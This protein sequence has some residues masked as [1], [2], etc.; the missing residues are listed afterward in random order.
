M[1]VNLKRFAI[2]AITAI[3]LCAGSASAP[4]KASPV[5]DYRAVD[6]A[7]PISLRPYTQV[8]EDRD[9]RLA[10]ADIL[11][12]EKSDPHRFRPLKEMRRLGAYSGSAWWL[13]TEIV[14]AA[15]APHALILVGG[16]PNLEQVDFYLQQDGQW[17]HFPAGTMIP[18]LQKDGATGYPA[19]QFTAAPGEAVAVWIRIESAS[20][21]RLEPALY[22]PGSFVAARASDNILGGV[23]TS[24]I[25]AL[26]ICAFILFAASH[27]RAFLW[28]GGICVTIALSEA[29]SRAYIQPVFWSMAS[30]WTYRLETVIHAIGA[31]LT[32]MFVYAMGQRAGL[33]AGHRKVYGVIAALLAICI[34]PT[35]FLPVAVLSMA[36][37]ALTVVMGICLMTSALG[38]ARQSRNGAILL[39]AAAVLLLAHA[40]GM[41]LHLPG[42]SPWLIPSALPQAGTPPVALFSMLAC[43]VALTLW[44][45]HRRKS[46]RVAPG[47]KQLAAKETG[48]LERD[49]APPHAQVPPATPAAVAPRDEAGHLATPQQ[50]LVLGYVGHDLRAPLAT[51]SG[52]ARLLRQTARPEQESYLDMIER[53]INYQFSLIDEILAY[54][55]YDLQPFDISAGDVQ[56]PALLEELARFGV[57]LCNHQGNAFRY[58]P[59][60]QLP[61]VVRLD[62][63]R[64][65]Q[66]V[67]NLL[68][69]AAKFTRDGTVCFE[70]GVNQRDDGAELMLQVT[71]DGTP[72]PVEHQAEIFSAFRQLRHRDAGSGLGLFIV[73]RIV[74]GMG[75][76][77]RFDSSPKLGN[78]F[79]ITLPIAVADATPIVTR[80]IHHV[81]ARDGGTQAIA[82]PPLAARLALAKLAREGE[83]SEIQQWTAETRQHHPQYEA[84]YRAVDQCVD[85]FDMECLQRL[86][87]LGI[88]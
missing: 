88:T 31:A 39:A 62:A 50:T 36:T 35:H 33:P 17:R 15:K 74:R 54:A 1:Q 84:F 73:D 41:S 52:Y 27:R 23:L 29:A 25:A 37:L 30:G 22:T 11:A 44:A 57:S 14:N 79:A 71:N 86:A 3:T 20:P 5:V 56:L 67:L 47:N 69:N 12:I 59:A 51:I 77:L 2:L 26:G 42:A 66:A 75:G 19:A 81:A 72:I 76:S 64:T 24:S 87:L 65:R 10:L 6:S 70:A 8:Y 46:Q 49:A 61:A 78:R 21:I 40:A 55:E 82:A 4:S 83:L 9:G 16:P 28:F 48:S 13:R 63:K 7:A 38:T 80:P 32:A 85:N 45:T 58:I 53:S 68:G 18:A 34:V 60:T 43:A